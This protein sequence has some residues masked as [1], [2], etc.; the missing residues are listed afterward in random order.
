MA[1]V[2]NE[3]GGLVVVPHAGVAR[4]RLLPK[5]EEDFKMPTYRQLE[6]IV[7]KLEHAEF[8]LIEAHN[9]LLKAKLGANPSFMAPIGRAQE[10]I[11]TATKMVRDLGE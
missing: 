10:T 3:A 2:G 6:A 4:L 9:Q 5:I 1:E 11:A 7:K 8:E